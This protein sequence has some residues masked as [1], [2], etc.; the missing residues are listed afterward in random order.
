LSGPLFRFTAV[1]TWPRRFGP[2]L[3]VYLA[4]SFAAWLFPPWGA[5]AALGTVPVLG[6]RLAWGAWFR[7]LGWLWLLIL[8]PVLLALPGSRPAGSL[9]AAVGRSLTFLVLLAASRWLSATS[10]VVEIRAALEALFRVFGRRAAGTL[11]LAGALALVFIP[12][13]AEQ[14]EAARQAGALRGAPARRP[15]L[16][17]RALA[18]PVLVRMIQKARHTAEALELR[19][20]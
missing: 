1:P 8:A 13:V 5:L 14:A 10:T 12:W 15:L 19:G 4:L 20:L 11:S 3:L 9:P 16:A 2:R 17:L 18:V 7:A 6:R